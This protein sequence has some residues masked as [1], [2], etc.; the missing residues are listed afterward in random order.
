MYSGGARFCRRMDPV[1][2]GAE[3]LELAYGTQL[4]GLAPSEEFELI[5]PGRGQLPEEVVE[6]GDEEAV[7]DTGEKGGHKGLEGEEGLDG[8]VAA[9]VD[10]LGGEVEV[11]GELVGCAEDGVDEPVEVVASEGVG[12][13]AGAEG[14]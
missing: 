7:G 13:L 11:V 6:L 3:E 12:V 14:V 10:G 4:K 2:E 5:P 9:V 8:V 1:A